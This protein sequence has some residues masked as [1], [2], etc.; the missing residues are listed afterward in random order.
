[1]QLKI[2]EP[3]QRWQ[4]SRAMMEM[5]HHR[6]RIFVDRLGWELPN[7][8]S[9]LEIDEFDN[10]EAV[11]IMAVSSDGSSHLGSVRLLPTTGPHMLNTLFADLCPGGAPMGEDVWEISRLVATP[12]GADGRNIL[13]VHRLLAMGIVEFGRLKGIG[14]FTLVAESHRMP[15]LLSVGWRVLPLSLPVELGGCLIEAAEILIEQRTF[16]QVR[17]RAGGEREFESSAADLRSA[18]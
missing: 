17:R 6:K 1:M 12:E 3:D 11:Y 5:H 15:A 13:R 9:W 4:F 8:G 2:V 14:R 18:A 7:K 16:D 10:D